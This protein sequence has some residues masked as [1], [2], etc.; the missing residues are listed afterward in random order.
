MESSP[1]GSHPSD[2]WLQKQQQ[3]GFGTGR[4]IVL[5]ARLTFSGTAV[6]VC[7]TVRGNLITPTQP[8]A[9]EKCPTEQG[10]SSFACGGDQ[11]F[12]RSENGVAEPPSDRGSFTTFQT[13]PSPRL[14]WIWSLFTYGRKRLPRS[15][16]G[17]TILRPPGPLDPPLHEVSPPQYPAHD[18]PG[19]APP[20]V[21]RDGNCDTS[22]PAA[23]SGKTL[24]PSPPP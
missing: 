21:A 23:G 18:P 15:P 12:A 16:V 7:M 14:G 1:Y 9:P 4:Q 20:A 19:L 17:F 2:Q 11:A 24:S 13:T 6:F 22:L 3:I 10:K 5:K 8:E